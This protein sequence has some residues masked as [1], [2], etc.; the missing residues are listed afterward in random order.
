MIGT[1]TLGP[2]EVDRY[3]VSKVGDEC[4][5]GMKLKVSVREDC[6]FQV[7]RGKLIQDA[8]E[9]WGP[10]YRISF[11]IY[12]KSWGKDVWYELIRFKLPDATNV[13]TKEARMPGIFV[14]HNDPNFHCCPTFTGLHINPTVGMDINVPLTL[15]TWHT[16]EI[17]Q[18]IAQDNRVM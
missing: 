3:F 10:T 11:K 15:R 18:D 9:T 5:A 7:R 4:R 12:I 2:F 1:Q 6:Y 14:R 17:V 8:I 16:I 13:D